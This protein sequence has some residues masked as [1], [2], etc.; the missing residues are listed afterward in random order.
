MSKNKTNSEALIH[1]RDVLIASK[2]SFKD[3]L[4][5][6]FTLEDQNTLKTVEK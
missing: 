1:D 4:Q 2:G 6:T 3:N 5:G